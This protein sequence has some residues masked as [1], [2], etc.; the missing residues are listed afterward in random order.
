[1]DDQS[2]FDPGFHDLPF[3]GIAKR[4]WSLFVEPFDRSRRREYLVRR[5]VAYLSDLRDTG[6]S[7]EIWVDGSF[8][9]TKASP[10]DVDVVVFY[11]HNEYNSLSSAGKQLFDR[12]TDA[13]IVRSGYDCDVYFVRN[14]SIDMRSY[15]RG[16]FGFSRNE[17]PKGIPRIFIQ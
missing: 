9:T 5:L 16:W 11:S 2:L 15:W 7:F 1:M 17:E 12:L 8:T 14:H 6:M 13:A 4:L 3:D 10:N